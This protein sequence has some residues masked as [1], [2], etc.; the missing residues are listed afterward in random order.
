MC[1]NPNQEDLRRLYDR[2]MLDRQYLFSALSKLLLP[3][4]ARIVD[5]G[6]GSGGST[7]IIRECYHDAEI[8]GIDNSIQAIHYASSLLEDKKIKLVN[9]DAT[10][11]PFPDGYFDCCVA[12]MVFDIVA[13][14][15]EII[16]EMVRLLKPLGTLLIYGNIRS[17]AQGSLQLINADKLINAYNRYVHLTGWIGFDIEYLKKV[18]VQKYGMTVRVHTIVKDTNFP[19]REILS[20]YYMLP[21]E[22]I[23]KSAETNILKKLGLV[24][25]EEVIEYETS[26][27]TLLLSSNE[28]LSFEQAI[29]YAT[30]E[31]AR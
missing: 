4:H 8:Y 14:P 29:L 20:K 16:S 21:E 31:K 7:Q 19:G 24:S 15:T 2:T 18:L 10:S 1:S 5:I 22:E 27:R 13:D 6:C 17:T 9:A 28:Y 30:K 12:K 26:L 23:K 3:H 11:L 25:S